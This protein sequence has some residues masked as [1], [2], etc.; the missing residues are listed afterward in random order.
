[1]ETYKEEFALYECLDVGKPI[2]HALSEVARSLRS[3]AELEDK[4]LPP[5]GADGT[6]I[7]FQLRKP[8]GVVGGI[9]GWN[10]P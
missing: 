6:N 5:S 9:A 4:L 10:T 7:S 8:I 3:C 1:M 2:A